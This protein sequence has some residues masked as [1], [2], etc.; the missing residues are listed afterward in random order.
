VA[1]LLKKGLLLEYVTLGWNV[2]GTVV[3]IAAAISARSVAL[4]GFG[5]DSLVE[6]GASL[7]VV[8]H[9]RNIHAAGRRNALRMI[10]ISFVLLA[11]YILAQSIHSLVAGLHPA[12]SLLGILWLTLTFA[13]MLALA[14]GKLRTGRALG[15][16]VLETEARVTL[17]DAML[18]ASTLLGL[19]LNALA[20]WW[21][22]D[23]LAGMVIV[24]YGFREG[25]AAW[26]ES[27]ESSAAPSGA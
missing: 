3:V 16:Q 11:I 6:I 21:W 4:A 25:R 13:V 5:L 15:N 26:I 19:V 18:A 1:D 14:A 22:A 24:F 20:G 10:S 17:V 8:W 2:I 9:L 7:V 27:R 23:P 12:A